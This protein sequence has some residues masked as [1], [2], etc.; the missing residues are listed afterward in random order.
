LRKVAVYN[1]IKARLHWILF[2]TLGTLVYSNTFFATFHFDDELFIVNNFAIRDIRNLGAIW[3]FFPTRFISF[4]TFSLNY[5][6]HGLNVFG[7]HLVNLAIHLCS[8]LLVWR[9][10]RL[11]FSTPAMKADALS[12]YAGPISLFAGLIFLCHPLQTESVTYLYQRSKCLAGC[13]YLLS[14]CLYFKSR[15]S[16]ETRLYVFSFLAGL[17]SVFTKEVSATLPFAVIL[18]EVFF[19]KTSRRLPWKRILPFFLLL[20][21]MP[22]ALFFAKPGIVGQMLQPKVDMAYFL[23][24]PRV[25]ITYLRLLVF[26]F[27]QNLDYNYPL[28]QSLLEPSAIASIALLAGLIY[29]AALLYR[30]YRLISFG[31]CWVILN[32]IPD[33]LVPTNDV[34]SESRLY[35]SLAGFSLALAAGVYYLSPQKRIKFVN[36]LLALLVAI[37]SFLTYNRNKVWQNDV[38]L[39]NDASRKAPAKERSYDNRGNAYLNQGDLDR[40]ISEYDKAIEINPG[41]FLAY[42]NRAGAYLKKGDQAKALSDY[43][44]AIELGPTF[45]EAYYSRGTLYLNRGD[46]AEALSDFSR[47]IAINPRYAE[48]YYNRGTLYLKR[49]DLA[50]A[51]SDLNRAIEINPVY[52]E[53]YNNRGTVHA[54]QGNIDAAIADY[55]KAI[56]GNRRFAEAYNNRGNANMY[57]GNFKQAISDY[58][59]A[60]AI[61]P[62]YLNAYFNRGLA[63]GNLGK[64]DEAVSDYN[65]AI[66]IN[67]GFN[68]AYYLRAVAYFKKQEYGKSWDDVRVLEMSGYKIQPDFIE[69]LKKASGRNE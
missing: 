33:S 26:P 53:A 17:A 3:N 31:I 67:P 34:I 5:H 48:A 38:T 62:G 25:Y 8:A 44:K 39:W 51:L 18:S 42:N 11:I 16:S 61:N 59:K 2:L 66:E 10:V 15:L 69:D 47:A 32:M 40:A 4:L 63:Y 6:F 57:A 55:G 60:I 30:R 20:V 52:A 49:G 43:G 23:T 46:L 54:R 68:E 24:Q 12:R 50:E 56:A 19:F 35:L 37:Y 64:M 41:S 22:A 14:L 7:Y 21:I 27:N 28:T 1:V 45:P 13:L 58:D 9:F 36:L 29:C 65:R